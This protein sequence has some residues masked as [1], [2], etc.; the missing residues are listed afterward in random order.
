ME[1]DTTM[2][3]DE[4]T[5]KTVASLAAKILNG[6]IPN[7]TKKQILSVAATALN[8]APNKKKGK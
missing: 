2:A 4:K 1:G 6:E 8:Q 3:K 5:S 7:P